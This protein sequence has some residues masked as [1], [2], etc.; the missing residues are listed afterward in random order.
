MSYEEYL[1]SLYDYR[2]C[3]ACGLDSIDAEACPY[4]GGDLT[5]V[6]RNA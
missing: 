1:S 2:Q 4:C 6:P 5:E 3:T